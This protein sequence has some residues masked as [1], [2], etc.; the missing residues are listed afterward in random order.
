MI[1]TINSFRMTGLEKNRKRTIR[2]SISGVSRISSIPESQLPTFQLGRPDT[3][4][5]F[6]QLRKWLTKFV[7]D[8]HEQGR[9]SKSGMCK[10]KMTVQNREARAPFGQTRTLFP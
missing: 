2:V 6:P 10:I 9:K 7:M 3:G 4:K 1:Y 5:R 8:L